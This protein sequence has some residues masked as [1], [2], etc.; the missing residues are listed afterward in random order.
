MRRRG[1]ALRPSLL[2]DEERAVLTRRS[3]RAS[4]AQALA[5][6]ARIVLACD[7]SDVASIIGVERGPQAVH[8]NQDR[9]RDPQLP[10][11]I[12]PTDLRRTA[13]TLSQWVAKSWTNRNRSDRKPRSS[14]SSPP[15]R[16]P[17]VPLQR[18]LQQRLSQP[19]E[20]S[21]TSSFGRP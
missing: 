20:A 1:P 14:T 2:S 21:S 18:P 13:L 6:R 8:L 5:L 15:C 12:L 19:R 4:S 9:R 11:P 10:R 3:R 17:A 7:G 16:R